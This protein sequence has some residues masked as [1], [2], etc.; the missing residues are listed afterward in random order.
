MENKVECRFEELPNLGVV[1]APMPSNLLQTLKDRIFKMA[2]DEFKNEQDVRDRLFGHV[3]RE[4]SL[5]DLIPQIEPFM[6]ELVKEYGTKWDFPY[7]NQTFKGTGVMRLTDLWVNFQKKHEFNPPHFHSG[8]LSFALWITI[9]YDIKE[10]EAVFP[11]I[12]GGIPRTSKFSFHYSTITGEHW[13]FSLPVDQGYEGTL[14]L[15]P[16]KLIHSVNPFYTSDGYRVSVSGN[17]KFEIQ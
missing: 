15:F 10:E 7:N 14:V 6:L 11:T 4:Y 8:V 2:T 5:A 9:P 13:S 12:S 1:V 16:A 3:D 17:L